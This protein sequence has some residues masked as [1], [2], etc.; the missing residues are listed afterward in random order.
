MQRPANQFGATLAVVMQERWT[1]ENA[2]NASRPKVS[3]AYGN[4]SNYTNS[5]LWMR[6]A[7]YLRL[8]NVEIGYK[9]TNSFI[10][11]VGVSSARVYVSGQNLLTWDKLKLV[12]PEQQASNSFA[13]PQLQLFNAGLNVQF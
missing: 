9:F 11:K 7:S 10:K 12:D 1:P 8:K 4:T 6:D 3:A 5:T 13:Y 2:A